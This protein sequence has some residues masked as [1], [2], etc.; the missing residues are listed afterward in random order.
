MSSPVPEN[1]P[2]KK[3]PTKG[4]RCPSPNKREYYRV[5]LTKTQHPGRFF[6]TFLTPTSPLREGVKSPSGSAPLSAADAV[7]A[8]PA[9]PGRSAHYSGQRGWMGPRVGRPKR[10]ERSGLVIACRVLRPSVEFCRL[11]LMP[12]REHVER[13]TR[14]GVRTRRR[15]SASKDLEPRGCDEVPKC[16]GGPGSRCC[17]LPGTDAGPP[18][19]PRP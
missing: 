16:N 6:W 1:P 12:G 14:L 5:P 9:A 15:A 19:R 11:P 3:P 4:P 18:A 13:L 2:S 17:N 7:R 8:Q 10:S